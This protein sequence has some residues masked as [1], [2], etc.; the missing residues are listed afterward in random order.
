MW[1][2]LAPPWQACLEQ[3]WT[4]YCS[5]CVPV[6]AAVTDAEGR[7]LA[8]GRNRV[9]QLE[10]EGGF[11]YGQ[12]LAHAEVNALIHLPIE[13][14]DRHA[15]A[16]YSTME[17]CPLCL[18]ALY[19]SGVRQLHYASRDP[20][21]GS[22]DLLGATPYLRRKPIQVSGPERP[23]L[24]TI[25]I[26]MHTEFELGFGLSE[27]TLRLLEAWSESLPAGVAMGQTLFESGALRRL[28]EQGLPAAQVF[29]RLVEMV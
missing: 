8:L 29:D 13:G 16:L 20:Y 6:G 15:C 1:D 26:A 2:A 4:A 5:G 10:E 28:R 23:D 22:A 3:A 27:T 12:P 19:T 24:E 25:L 18:G 17:P 9:F 14:L 11:L 21:A 7:I